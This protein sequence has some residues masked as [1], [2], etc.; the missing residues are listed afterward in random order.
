MMEA[1]ARRPEK[2]LFQVFESSHRTSFRPERTGR[3]KSLFG[4]YYFDEDLQQD[5]EYLTKHMNL[6]GVWTVNHG[7]DG[8]GWRSSSVPVLLFN[9]KTADNDKWDSEK[10]FDD[11]YE[12]IPVIY[13]DIA[14][15]DIVKFKD[16]DM[17]DHDMSPGSTEYHLTYALSRFNTLDYV[18]RGMPTWKEKV[19]AFCWETLVD[20]GH[21]IVGGRDES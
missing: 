6:N 8:S 20:K 10:W 16:F 2:A 19:T 1:S 7:A 4:V 3:E 17:Y 9:K 12:L 11:T 21:H 15:E 14:D 13:S 5:A 18:K